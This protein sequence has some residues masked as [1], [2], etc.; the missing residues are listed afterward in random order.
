MFKKLTIGLGVVVAIA[1]I[2]ICAVPLVTVPYVVDVQYEE[3]EI[4]YETHTETYTERE[5]YNKSIPIDYIVTNKGIYDWFWSTGSD[6]WVTIRNT[7][8]KSGT[9]N[10]KFDLTLHGGA[11]TTK[12]GSK[13]IALGDTERVEVK[14]SGG[15]V[16]TFSYSITPPTKT[17]IDYRD[18][19]KTREITVPKQRTVIRTRQETRYKEVTVLE[20]LVSY[21]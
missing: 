17:V 16:K 6:V 15:Y 9:F 20:Y 12:Y 19:K 4:Y 10:V 21:Q 3:T 5:P 18:V 8:I 13:Y 1:A 2:I 14:Y 11:K 7:D